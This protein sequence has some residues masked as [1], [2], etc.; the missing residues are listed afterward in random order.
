MFDLVKLK[1]G[2]SIT[3]SKGPPQSSFKRDFIPKS[4]ALLSITSMFAAFN[5]SL[6]WFNVLMILFII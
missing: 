4:D 3:L 2:Y 1:N 6:V 5:E